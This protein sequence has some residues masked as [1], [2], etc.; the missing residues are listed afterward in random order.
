MIADRSKHATPTELAKQSRPRP[1]PT[2]VVDSSRDVALD[3]DAKGRS[4][5]GTGG[6]YG[7]AQGDRAATA[8]QHAPVGAGAADRAVRFINLN[9]PGRRLP[10]VRRIAQIGFE[11]IR[12]PRSRTSPRRRR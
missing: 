5:A 6:L 4:Q 9:E 1:A 7:A 8:A 12:D 10:E 2:R 11:C 3:A